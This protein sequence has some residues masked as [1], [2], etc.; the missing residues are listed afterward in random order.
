MVVSMVKHQITSHCYCH[1]KCSNI[2]ISQQPLEQS[3]FRQQQSICRG[4][5]SRIDMGCYMFQWAGSSW[6]AKQQN[7]KKQKSKRVSKKKARS[8][9]VAFFNRKVEKQKSKFIYKRSRI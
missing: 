2:G 3:Q 1:E 6:Q 4:L 5:I 7:S 9:I 8:K